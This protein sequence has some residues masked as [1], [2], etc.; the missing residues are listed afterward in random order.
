MV[1]FAHNYPIQ[2]DSV[3]VIVASSFSVALFVNLLE[4]IPMI[5]NYTRHWMINYLRNKENT[6]Q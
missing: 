3:W 6:I 1:Y 5:L 4:N 2:P